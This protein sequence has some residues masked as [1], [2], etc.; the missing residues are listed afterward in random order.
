MNTVATTLGDLMRDLVQSPVVDAR[1]GEAFAPLDV[2]GYNYM[3]RRYAIDADQ[4]P[5][6]GHRR[7]RDPPGGHRHR[8]AARCVA[9]PNVIGDFV[10]TGWDYLGEAGIGQNDHGEQTDATARVPR[11]VPVADRVVRRHR[12]HRSPS[13]AVVLPRDRLRPPLRPVPR[14]APPEPQ[15]PTERPSTARGPGPTSCRAGAGPATRATPSSPSRS[16]PP[17]MR[18]SSCSTAGRSVAS[19]PAPT[20]PPGRLRGQYQPGELE[21]V[22]WYGRCEVGRTS[23]RSA[24][25][26]VRARVTAERK[27]VAADHHDLA[28]VEMALVDDAGVVHTTADRRIEV[29]IDRPGVLL[30]SAAPTPSWR[31]PSPPPGAP[32]TTATPSRSSDPPP[33]GHHRDR[34]GGRLRPAVGHRR[35]PLT[36]AHPGQA[37][38]AL[39]S[40]G[41][42]SPTR[43]ARPTTSPCSKAA[44]RRVRRRPGGVR[45]RLEPH[46]RVLRTPGWLSQIAPAGGGAVL[47]RTTKVCSMTTCSSAPPPLTT[48]SS[49]PTLRLP[50]SWRSMRTVVSGG[51]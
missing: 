48:S 29:A 1:P 17:P 35:R 12:H 32:P 2:A 11:R 19:P 27:E 23:L 49:R 16:T 51:S 26:V 44:W 22:A 30:A 4:P 31:N 25:A 33:P 14:G 43:P 18:S 15:P 39:P 28:Y 21:A 47:D 13:P 9:I 20:R 50:I 34:H 6:P 46:H 42:P 8:L 38:V 24:A 36:T 41:P 5:G 40:D 10:W 3:E 7:H 45:Q 37:M